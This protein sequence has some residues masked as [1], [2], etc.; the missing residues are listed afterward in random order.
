MTGD[1]V[2][3]T[4]EALAIAAGD[5]SGLWLERILKSVKPVRCFADAH[6]EV[7]VYVQ[8]LPNSTG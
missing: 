4:P 6:A 2:V 1:P 3:Q 8:R 7:T 5:S